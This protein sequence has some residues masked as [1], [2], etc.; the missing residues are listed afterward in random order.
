MSNYIFQKQTPVPECKKKKIKYVSF[1]KNNL[2][3]ATSQVNIYFAK[4]N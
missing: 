1:L 2:Q 3:P 4:V